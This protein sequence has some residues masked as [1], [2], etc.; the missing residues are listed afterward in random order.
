VNEL[1]ECDINY[2]SA[3]Y[4]INGYLDYGFTNNNS[5]VYNRMLNYEFKH[6]TPTLIHTGLQQIINLYEQDRSNETIFLILITDGET[7]NREDFKSKLKKYP[8]N[9]TKLNYILL[10]IPSN[11]DNQY[12]F[13]E[14]N[15]S[16]KRLNCHN[17]SLE[18]I[19]NSY[20]LCST[21]T[22]KTT[23]TYT[24]LTST[25]RTSA[26]TSTSTS[27]YTSTSRT[28]ATTSTS[29][30][31]TYTSTSRTPDYTSSSTSSSASTYT[32]KTTSST[33]TTTT[34][35]LLIN[36]SLHNKK[37]NKYFILIILP[38]IIIAILFYFRQKSKS[39]SKSKIEKIRYNP[40]Y[41][42]NPI[43]NRTIENAVYETIDTTPYY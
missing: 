13:D 2:A 12:V 34:T 43:Y 39:K 26:T 8:F 33:S 31:T 24:S 36:K 21:S 1:T 19:L 28:S 3:Q 17:N 40:L 22:S 20:S 25:S 29:R 11:I 16:Y 5:Y 4:N 10:K 9:S 23:S 6:G 27:T 35:S 18:Y 14:L 32:S 15:T 7:L 41:N 38:I 30:T 37:S 42:N